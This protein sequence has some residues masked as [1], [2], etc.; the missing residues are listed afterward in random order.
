MAT[1]QQD[2]QL[3]LATILEDFLKQ[4]NIQVSVGVD[5]SSLKKAD[6]TFGGRDLPVDP[7][8]LR[9][10]EAA[11]WVRNTLGVVGGRDLPADPSEEDFRI[12][13]RSGILLCNVLNRVKPGAVPKVVE[14]PNDPL[15]NQDGAAL[16]AF[17][18]F[19]N[20]RN[21]LVFVEE[22]GIPTFE[23]SDFEKGGK[24]ARIVECVLAL[25]SYREWKQ[26]GGS[27]TW[28][29]ILNSKPTTF[30]IAKQ[31]KRKDS[32]VPVD[33]VTNSPSST[34]SSEQPLLDQSDSNTK[35]DGTASSIDAIVR[36]VFSD[37]KQE[38]IPVIVEDMLKSV[39]VEYERRLATQNELLLMSAGNRDKL[40]S[41]DL[42]R[43]I[44]G[45]EETLSDA[46]YGEENVTEIVNNNMEASQDSNVEE[47]ENQ[48]YELYAISK[49]KT[50]KQQLII[51]R[52]QTH[53]EE[54]KHD[55]K[56]V[57]AGLSLLQMKYQQEFTS[58]GKHL[59]G[60]TYAATGYQRVL[61]E[62]RKLY[63]Q[64][65]DLKGSIRVY[66]RVRP[67]LPG[68]KSVLTTVDHL[69]DSTLSIATPSKYGKEGQKT[70]TF[71]KVFGPSASQEAVFADTQ[72][73]IRSVLDGYN[74]CIFA[75]GQTGSGKTFTMMGP[76]ELTDETLGV[77]YRALS[78]LFHLSKIRNSTQDGINV[79]EATL[80]PVSTTSDVIHLMNIGQKNRAVSATAM[81]D[82]S[83]RSHSCLTV[84]VQ[85]KDL[86]SGVTLRGSM[87]LVD[88][89]G[90][91]RIDKS[92][93]TGDRLKEAQHINK[94]LSALGDVIASLSQKNNHIPY[95]NSK[96][97][98]LLQD[99][100]GGQAKTLMFIHISP[101]L[102]DLGETLS[103]LKFAERVATVDLG[104]ARVNKDTSEV[105]ELKEQIASLKLALARK[106]SGAD[107]TQL[108]RPLTPDKLLRK[109]S[110]GVSSS[111]SKSANS[112]RQVQ[113][114][115]KPSQIDDVN[116]IEG[117][118]DSASS[119]DLQGLVGSPSWKTPPRDG[120]EEDMEFII[121][122]SEWVDKHE[123]EITRSSKPENRAH[124]QLEKRTSS[125]KREATRGVD[126]NKC[127][128]SVD[129]GLEVRKI[130][131]EEEANES[132][133]TATSDCSETNLMWQLNV[134]VNMPRPASNGS[135]T[136]LKK[137]QSKISRVA[138]ETRS[139][140]PSLIPTPTRTLSLGAAIS[141]PGQTSSRHNNS[142]VVVK[143]RQNPK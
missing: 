44:S 115:H 9:R 93:V 15:V 83:S 64:V 58:L 2:S 37:M 82:R 22:M 111:F 85:G 29:Y 119:L 40:G 91:E 84:H 52:Q 32:E 139:M 143:K 45:N 89:A 12:A 88:L 124:T 71:N 53:T 76:N 133:E 18:Y 65:Q 79:P 80:V 94:S 49:E 128:S 6:E 106:E 39:M 35:N 61:E 78:D 63:N 104:A 99:A 24:S 81:N 123:D 137:N 86:T 66:C 5:S 47:L 59:H 70:F 67:F 54:L 50:E 107:Q 14:A 110:L 95:R 56:A 28:R 121:P 46:S 25:K 77:N 134:Q 13:L 74:V 20:L 60:L 122:G 72:P 102:E 127:N 132:D 108:Q 129:K 38:D 75:Y 136:K 23:V 55:L 10:Y 109:K 1:E 87:H 31:Y 51:E 130:P 68:Q 8:D 57:K 101:E 33:A 43:T 19:E 141:S 11:R 62:N 27:G 125:L 118:S 100:L 142:T 131:Y 116:S 96:L 17:Q 48:D 113:T 3:C 92:E 7:S 4:R 26:S 69:E 103:T 30:G 90:S 120:K 112:T 98:Q 138:A 114:K 36:A 42:G 34:P 16:S 21:F 140:I 117:Q 97:T 105:K 135:S 126:K 41:G 73:L